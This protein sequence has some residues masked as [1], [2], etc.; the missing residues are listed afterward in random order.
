MDETR[1]NLSFQFLSRHREKCLR[2]TYLIEALEI[3]HALEH[4]R[5]E[6]S[7]TI[8]L[9]CVFIIFY[10]GIYVHFGLIYV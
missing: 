10:L 2:Y 9:S 6:I 3:L 8:L 5:N 7:Q 1:R 4:H